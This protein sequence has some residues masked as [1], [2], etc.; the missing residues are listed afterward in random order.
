MLLSTD[1]GLIQAHDLLTGLKNQSQIRHL[2]TATGLL[3]LH[4]V[5]K[6]L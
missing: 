3:L 5:V 1:Q 4:D 6:I 2:K